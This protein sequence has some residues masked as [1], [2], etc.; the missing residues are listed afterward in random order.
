MMW[1]LC[2]ALLALTITI[3]AARAQPYDRDVEMRGLTHAGVQRSLGV[4]VPASYDAARPAPLI[5]ALH[6]RFS[7]A[8]AFHAL[9]GLAAVAEARGAIVLYPEAAGAFW[10]DGADFTFRRE[11]AQDDAGFIAAAIDATAGAYAVDRA[12]IYLV[13]Y[14]V[15][16]GLAYRLACAGAPRFAAVAAV[17]ALLWDYAPDACPGAAPAPMLIVHGR[18]DDI[19]PVRGGVPPGAVTARRF[20]ADETADYW[21]GVNGCAGRAS[22]SGRGGSAYY[23]DCRNG[24]AVAYV[25]VDGGS[26]DWFHDGA[27][28]AL[29]QHGV[30]A[31]AVVDSFFFDRAN[32][33]LPQSR[34]GRRSR[35]W[36]VYAPPSYDP[37]RPMPAVVMLHGRPGTATGMALISRMHEVAARRG[38]IVVYPEGIDNEWNAQFDLIGRDSLSIGG[39]RSVLPQD[40][41]GFLKTLVSDLR[42]DL[43]IDP[44]RMYVAGF[45]N[46]GF[47]TL[48]MACSGSD[49]FA[50]FAEVGAA[51]YTVMNDT[52]R[53]SPAA[54]ILL[55]HGS[56]D[57]SIPY[58]GVEVRSAADGQ[59]TRVTL[60]VPNTVSLFVQRNR[61]SLSG[62]STTFAENGG[63]PGTHVIRFIPHDCPENAPVEFWLINGGGH[64]WPGVPGMLPE[65]NFGLVNMDINAGEVIWDFLSRQTLSS[66]QG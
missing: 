64:Q 58:D 36:I 33:R 61:C 60:S 56:A 50:G 14:D 59:E 48:R 24:A 44:D 9:S 7:S 3:G 55:M 42:V 26:H 11:E 46:G 15:G 35:A 45:S 52:C 62:Q 28:Y 30:D 19:F 12:R 18:R 13:G 10:N 65:E 43:N 39:A 2:A 4:Y 6:G 1:R 29:N 63:S 53:R 32:F 22:A 20:S 21:R 41:V 40:D 38:F 31:A 17:S 34:A 47:M 54:P 16:G 66:R 37:A 57:L 5:V 23:A 51:L 27:G 8:K 25:G 49:V